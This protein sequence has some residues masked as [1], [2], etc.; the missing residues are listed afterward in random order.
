MIIDDE[1]ALDEVCRSLDR[2]R[3]YRERIETA[4]RWCADARNYAVHARRCD[5]FPGR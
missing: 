2:E 5:E 4:L 3:T 1:Q